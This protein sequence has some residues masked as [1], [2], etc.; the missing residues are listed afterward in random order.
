MTKN[1]DDVVLSVRGIQKSFGKQHVL[2]GVD[3]DVH[4]GEVSASLAP[5][6]P[7]RPHCSAA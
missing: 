2:R 5:A 6:G 4:R 3:L 1:S 7:A